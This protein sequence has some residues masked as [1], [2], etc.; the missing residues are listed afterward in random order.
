MPK[1]LKKEIILHWL[2]SPKEAT[3]NAQLLVKEDGVLA[4]VEIAIQIFHEFDSSFEVKTLIKDG[5]RVNK[6][7][8]AFTVYGTHRALY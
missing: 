4:G 3:G 8:I 1:I 6:G 5:E 2:V 7:D